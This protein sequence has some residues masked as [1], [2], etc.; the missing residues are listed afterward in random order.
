MRYHEITEAPIS[1]IHLTGSPY[2]DEH[3][4][5]SFDDGRGFDKVDRDL[6]KSD[7]GRA[8]MMRAFEKTP[9]NIEVFFMNA[10]DIDGAGED[11]EKVDMVI[12]D[13]GA[14]IYDSG[15]HSINAVPGK[16]R[17]IMLSNL[18]PR[19]GKVPM[20]D[21]PKMPM[22]AW[23]LAHKIGHSFQDYVLTG[24]WTTPIGEL[25]QQLNRCIYKLGG[26][27]SGKNNANFI[28]TR[29]GYPASHARALTMKSARDRT[30][31]NGFEIFPELIA[32][33]LISGHV[34]L[35]PKDF[36]YR[37]ETQYNP[38]IIKHFKKVEEMINK[39]IPQ[40]LEC[41]VGKV[42]VEV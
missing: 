7:K 30:L 37:S 16:I 9:F 13:K 18:S 34:K 28:D 36:L 40:L 27:N 23:T 22:T 33:Y 21:A 5:N 17:V 3:T 12:R 35:D 41:L 38:P 1:D 39:I 26:I 14:A 31:D 11:N 29:F 24:Q 10:T 6:L 8:K 42:V 25:V 19:R 4:R 20:S 15:F 32:Q 2:G